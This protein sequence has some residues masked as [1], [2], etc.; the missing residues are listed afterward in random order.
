M[1]KSAVNNVSW[2]QLITFSKSKD[3]LVM[4]KAKGKKI[5]FTTQKPDGV[6]CTSF[7]NETEGKS[8]C[9]KDDTNSEE[10]LQ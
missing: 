3:V 1:M 7:S 6:K 5:F 4:Q 2:Q 10:I 8:A 9:D